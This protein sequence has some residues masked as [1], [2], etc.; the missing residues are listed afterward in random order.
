MQFGDY[1]AN[2]PLHF[3]PPTFLV[4]YTVRPVRLVAPSRSDHRQ[5]RLTI[6][7]AP[8][9]PMTSSPDSANMSYHRGRS[10]QTN[11]SNVAEASSSSSFARQR[12]ERPGTFAVPDTSASES[13]DDSSHHSSELAEETDCPDSEAESDI[14]EWGVTVTQRYDISDDEEPEDEDRPE[15]DAQHHTLDD[16]ENRIL[17]YESDNG[18]ISDVSDISDVSR[19]S[20]PPTQ[21]SPPRERQFLMFDATSPDS[22]DISEDSD[23][24]N[25]TANAIHEATLA[26][27]QDLAKLSPLQSLSASPNR[28][29]P[30]L[31]ASQHSMSIQ[32]FITLPDS[33]KV[34]PSMDSTRAQLGSVHGQ[35]GASRKDPIIIDA[36]AGL[37][38]SLVDKQHDTPLES[39]YRP[40]SP[41]LRLS[42]VADDHT[43]QSGYYD[44][45]TDSLRVSGPLIEAHGRQP[46]P[47]DAAM[48]KPQFMVEPVWKRGP[49]SRVTQQAL[50]ALDFDFKGEGATSGRNV[51]Q[52]GPFQRPSNTQSTK[53]PSVEA[54]KSDSRL[55]IQELI[56]PPNASSPPRKRGAFEAG[57]DDEKS[58]TEDFGGRQ[59]DHDGF[60]EFGPERFQP[61]KPK[62]SSTSQQRDLLPRPRNIQYLDLD[63]LD[64]DLEVDED[65]EL[66]MD[67]DPTMDR[68]ELTQEQKASNT[69][70]SKPGPEGFG[71]LA[72]RKSYLSDYNQELQA[73]SGKEDIAKDLFVAD[74]KQEACQESGSDLRSK[75]DILGAPAT[76]DDNKTVS[77]TSP[78]VVEKTPE[79]DARPRKRVKIQ[80]A[81][82]PTPRPRFKHLMSKAIPFMAGAAATA[83]TIF[84]GASM[85]ISTMHEELRQEALLDLGF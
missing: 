35:H 47:S 5:S 74:D 36:V 84:A 54:V 13:E 41:D 75:T 7:S 28:E 72:T 81:A 38:E 34:A 23:D 37:L 1:I 10:V 33:P 16:E 53:S 62:F 71:L 68:S 43:R 59:D 29:S 82:E 40:R 70:A 73:L 56:N 79:Q 39:S 60:F 65:D 42:S 66:D 8:P 50:G 11:Y 12:G 57:F 2:G 85:L 52:D 15:A 24:D 22:V 9:T 67:F 6:A 20:L 17:E 80:T 30:V 14:D 31:P 45:P 48:A 46:S 83:A 21:P 77:G 25:A 78:N 44:G 61:M 26:A 69:A 49:I 51:Y 64:T 76:K 55:T 63:I 18:S 4:E 27:N 32:N 3:E 58:E 19:A